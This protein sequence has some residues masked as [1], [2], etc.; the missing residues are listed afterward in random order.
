MNNDPNGVITTSNEVF[1]G[2]NSEL[3]ALLVYKRFGRNQETATAAWRRLLGNSAT[4]ADFMTLVY[5]CDVD[6]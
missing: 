1:T 3:M 6:L 4:E 5:D 2:E